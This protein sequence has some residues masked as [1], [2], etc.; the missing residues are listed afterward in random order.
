M[1]AILEAV[2]HKDPTKRLKL[3]QLDCLLSHGSLWEDEAP[4]ASSSA[5]ADVKP[6][7]MEERVEM[8]LAVVEVLDM[9]NENARQEALLE[10]EERRP[11]WLRSC[12]EWWWTYPKFPKKTTQ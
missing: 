2:L 6:S 4:T 9:I 7:S 5:G 10:G 12:E 3:E 11:E 8:P 1:V